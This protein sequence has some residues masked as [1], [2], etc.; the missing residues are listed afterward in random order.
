MS[1]NGA[2]QQI[3]HLILLVHG[4]GK[5][6]ENWFNKINKINVLFQ[7]VCDFTQS[8]PNAKNVK[9]VGVEWHSAL[10]Q[11]TDTLIHKVSPPT[12]P[13]VRSLLNHTVFDL[14]FWS[15]PTWS[16]HIYTEVG[17]Q[18]NKAYAEFIATHPS[19]RGKVHIL[20]HSLGSMI[21]YDILCHQPKDSHPDYDEAEGNVAT[22]VD[23]ENS[24]ISPRKPSISS[25]STTPAT[26]STPARSSPS[27]PEISDEESADQ[28]IEVLD[29]IDREEVK[30]K[31]GTDVLFN[32]CRF[33]FKL[34]PGMFNIS[35]YSSVPTAHK[36]YWNHRDV[37][38][39][40][41]ENLP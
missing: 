28:V 11:K 21:T 26:P 13:S 10:H 12:I 14:L 24:T 19:F 22:E 3:D 16:Q 27:S 23:L 7:N 5:H 41:A 2:E 18:L 9:F 38:F 37:M 32:G 29:K 39:F 30:S 35:E 1:P 15:S 20:A 25:T 34:K 40:I 17:Q 6:E 4:V 31:N 33:D 8:T 36:S